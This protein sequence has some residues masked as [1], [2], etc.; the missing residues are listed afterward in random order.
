MVLEEVETYYLVI[1]VA[2]YSIP[3]IEAGVPLVPVVLELP[4]DSLGGYVEVFES[5]D[6]VLACSI[7]YLTAP[8]VCVALLEPI[9]LKINIIIHLQG[10]EIY[11][12]DWVCLFVE[13]AFWA[14]DFDIDSLLSSF[15]E[16]LDF[17]NLDIV[18]DDRVE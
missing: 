13:E 8:S 3:G 6:L 14:V 15:W 16:L 1:F 9:V 12:M 11:E 5:F 17:L 7:D 10:Y 2:N 18:D 4:I